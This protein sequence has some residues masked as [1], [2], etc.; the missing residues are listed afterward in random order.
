MQEEGESEAEGEKRRKEAS[1]P[2]RCY[3]KVFIAPPTRSDS[4]PEGGR[5]ITE[6]REGKNRGRGRELAAMALMWS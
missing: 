5:R 1:H 4:T 3:Q 2:S 6:K